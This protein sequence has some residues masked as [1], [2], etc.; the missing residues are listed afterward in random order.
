M[1]V[2]TCSVDGDCRVR[3]SPRRGLYMKHT[4]APLLRRPLTQTVD[5][6]SEH[7][8]ITG[9]D[10][11]R[12]GSWETWSFT[13]AEPM[14]WAHLL[15]RD[16]RMFDR[17]VGKRRSLGGY[18]GRLLAHQT[19]WA[20]Q[21][22]QEVIC[23][24]RKQKSL[25]KKRETDKRGPKLSNQLISVY[26]SFL[27]LAYS[28]SV[29]IVHCCFRTYVEIYYYIIFRSFYSTFLIF[30][31]P[32]RMNPPWSLLQCH[33]QDKHGLTLTADKSLGCRL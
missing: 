9:S 14:C 16:E 17:H 4:L 33:L 3:G 22:R 27:S 10:M 8:G 7:I 18:V 32:Q 30:F 23:R 20:L 31:V 13:A 25:K 19:Q 29:F 28:N 6:V 24:N 12:R 5:W 15:D 21:Q 1:S 26:F 11:K 2:H